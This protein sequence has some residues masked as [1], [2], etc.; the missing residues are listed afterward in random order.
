MINEENIKHNDGDMKTYIKKLENRI[1][2]DNQHMDIDSLTPME[3][4]KYKSYLEYMDSK[5]KLMAVT[6]REYI[7]EEL[8]HVINKNLNDKQFM[9]KLNNKIN[10]ALE[11]LN[12]QDR[13]S[14]V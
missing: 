10:E 13:K 1:L 12:E 6:A 7:K 4:Y 5:Y 2:P 9:E 11:S 3:F 14:V 8:L